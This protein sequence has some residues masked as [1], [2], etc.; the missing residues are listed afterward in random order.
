M[1]AGGGLFRL[2]SPA[3]GSAPGSRQHGVGGVDS[4]G[5]FHFLV[6][7][8][9]DLQSESCEPHLHLKDKT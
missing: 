6:D 4:N 3:K 1:A 5:N 8:L 2:A 9:M 7:K